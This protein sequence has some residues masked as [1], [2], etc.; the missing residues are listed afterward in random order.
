MRTPATLL[1]DGLLTWLWRKP[2]RMPKA[3]K[4]YGYVARTGLKV[5]DLNMVLVRLM[6]GGAVGA[7]NVPK[8]RENDGAIESKSQD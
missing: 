2:E 4:V 8:R 3:I 1:K 5:P 6:S 7:T